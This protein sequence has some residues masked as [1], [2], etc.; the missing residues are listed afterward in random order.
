[1]SQE[2][3]IH[4]SIF[5]HNMA[6][7]CE[8]KSENVIIGLARIVDL[9][10]SQKDLPSEFQEDLDSFLSPILWDATK[11]FAFS[12]GAEWSTEDRGLIFDNGYAGYEELA[13][14][15]GLLD[16]T[17]ESKKKREVSLFLNKFYE[18]LEGE[19]SLNRT[20]IHELLASCKI[21]HIMITQL[22]NLIEQVTMGELSWEKFILSAKKRL[23]E[24]AKDFNVPQKQ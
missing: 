21:K 1:M 13:V 23:N 3:E 9:I 2:F 5:K 4:S 8:E 20:L 6:T 7:W 22:S 10:K 18:L 17:S 24:L 14:K 19:K 15:Y 12:C 16:E 11:I